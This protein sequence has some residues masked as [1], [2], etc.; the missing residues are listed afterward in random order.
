[1]AF[2]KPKLVALTGTTKI[3]LTFEWIEEWLVP[4]FERKGNSLVLIK[5]HKM[6][7][8]VMAM[9]DLDRNLKLAVKTIV[10][11]GPGDKSVTYAQAAPVS[12][13][14][15][16]TTMKPPTFG[17]LI[18]TDDSAPADIPHVPDVEDF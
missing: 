5:D 6:K 12:N 8:Q 3:E 16:E 10:K 7:Q 13:M 15:S 1:M 17:K 9:V 4:K 11:A 14:P 18:T 2:T